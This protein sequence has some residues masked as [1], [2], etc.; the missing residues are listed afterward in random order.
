[1]RFSIYCVFRL[2]VNQ[3]TKGKPKMN[4]DVITA[5]IAL[6][7]LAKI[8]WMRNASPGRR[9]AMV[10]ELVV[11]GFLCGWLSGYLPYPIRMISIGFVSIPLSA[12]MFGDRAGKLI[13]RGRIWLYERKEFDERSNERGR[14]DCQNSQRGD[15][16]VSSPGKAP[17]VGRAFSNGRRVRE[18]RPAEVPQADEDGDE[19]LD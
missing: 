13:D 15:R 9:Y 7:A 1:M 16:D 11:G 14:A 6:G 18:H 17:G 19:A 3:A 8:I 10:A 4:A 2:G 5:Y 12:G